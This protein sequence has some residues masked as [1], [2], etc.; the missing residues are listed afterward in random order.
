MRHSGVFAF[1][2]VAAFFVATASASETLVSSEREVFTKTLQ[3]LVCEAGKDSIDITRE[4]NV[5]EVEEIVAGVK[6][7]K[8]YSTITLHVKNTGNVD[9]KDVLVKER[10]PDSVAQ[11]PEDLFNFNIPP[12]SFEK[13]SVVVTWLFDE[14]QAGEE[15]QV[16]Y[17]VEKKLDEQV[18]NDY[19][20][21]KVLSKAAGAPGSGSA[22][23]PTPADS[24]SDLTLPI[25]GVLLLLIGGGVYW[26]TRQSSGGL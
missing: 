10:V 5:Y 6:T 26:F 23:G 11:R 3:P 19:E 14:V 22:S 25:L 21:P 17:T 16:S 9:L 24:G 15:K 4:L 18:L 8:H 13:G 12:T 2:V 20:P 1:L 7:V